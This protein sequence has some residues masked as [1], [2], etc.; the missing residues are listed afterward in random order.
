VFKGIDYQ[1]IAVESPAM[2][3]EATRNRSSGNYIVHDYHHPLPA[4]LGK[5]DVIVANGCFDFCE[6]LIQVL[7]NMAAAPAPG[8]RFYFTINERHTDLPFHDEQWADAGGSLVDD[9][10]FSGST[11]S[12]RECGPTQHFHLSEYKRLSGD[13]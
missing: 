4:E 7:G 6:D 9:R 2:V 10:M 3:D 8:G 13:R 12:R 11:F 5:F 1:G